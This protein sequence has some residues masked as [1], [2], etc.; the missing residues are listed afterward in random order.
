M[1]ILSSRPY[2]TAFLTL[3]ALTSYYYYTATCVT[4]TKNTITMAATPDLLSHLH[5]SATQS[6]TNP[7]ILTLT[8]KNTHP[9]TAITLLNW[10]SP[11]DPLA[12]QLGLV[13]VYPLEG[14]EPLP[15][16]TIQ[17]SRKL[18]PGRDQLVA[19]QPGESRAQ[20]VTLRE[21]VV[22]FKKVAEGPDGKKKVR[23][24]CRGRWK[25]VW[26]AAGVEEVGDSA[27]EKM[28]ADE[29]AVGGQ[30]EAEGVEVEV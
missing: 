19:L 29:G 11:L 17:V 24:V 5:V 26:V 1:S 2:L 9:S 20:E 18:P 16:A 8:L 12:L 10:E 14:D 13:S 25:A 7:P 22:P 15:L 30:W 3:F 4:S 21:P 27:L 6:S 23:V 28:E